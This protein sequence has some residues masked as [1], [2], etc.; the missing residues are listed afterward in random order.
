MT[1]MVNNPPA[2]QD[3]W[4]WSLGWEDPLG[5]GVATH[6]N[7][8]PWRSLAGNS[9]W[10]HKE[11]DKTERLSTQH[12]ISHCIYV[13]CIFFIRS[14]VS[15]HLG[16]FHDLAL[17]NSAAMNTGVHASFWIRVFSGYGPRSGIAGLYGNK[18]HKYFKYKHTH[19]AKLVIPI[20]EK[21]QM[22]GAKLDYT[23]CD[24]PLHEGSKS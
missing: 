16:F 21:K 14:S 1:H 3:T 7:I 23:Q 22:N 15:G 5:E 8:L 12:T 4:V 17:V 2:M 13:Y 11:S 24:S 19:K 9:P 10:G 20:R 18:I 6:S